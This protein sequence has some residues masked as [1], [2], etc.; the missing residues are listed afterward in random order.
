MAPNNNRNLNQGVL[1]LWSI[2]GDP[3]LN[4]SWVIMET[5]K[6]L[7]WR[8]TSIHTNAGNNNTRR[9]KLASGK[10]SKV[11]DWFYYFGRPLSILAAEPLSV[12]QD[13]TYPFLTHSGREKIA[14]IFQT[15][16]SKA[17]MI[18]ENRE[19][20]SHWQQT[21]SSEVHSVPLVKQSINHNRPSR[22]AA[23]ALTTILVP[24]L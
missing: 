6:W 2:F 12:F 13:H 4:R 3:S 1:H 8:L 22:P 21:L 23:T 5:S 9:P 17:S 18:W 20:R 7:T 11:G 14:A 16:L 19:C 15:T 24:Y 10:N